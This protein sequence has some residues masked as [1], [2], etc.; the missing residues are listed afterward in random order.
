M[1]KYIKAAFF[2]SPQI[3]GLGAVPVNVLGIIGFVALGFGHPGFWLLGLGLETAYL[4]ATATN[5]RFQHAV[6]ARESTA[7]EEDDELVR[8]RL[9]RKL[10]RHAKRR[11]EI[12]EERCLKVLHAHRMEDGDTDVVDA[13]RYA[14]KKLAWTYLKLLVA[15]HELQNP[16]TSAGEAELVRDIRTLESEIVNERLS[17]AARD[18]KVATLEILKKRLRNIER[19]E[20]YIEEIES[21]LRRIEAEVDLALE[22]ATL[23]ES[24]DVIST[25]LD[26]ASYLLTDVFVD[27]EEEASIARVD[28]SMEEERRTVQQPE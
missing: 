16:H 14:L 17:V 7:M 18:S 4:Y 3:P 23:K 8:S 28:R 27:E 2:F 12:L 10:P 11:L 5:D 19:R 26:V 6:R 9:I 13:N 20:R 22:N 25:D 24:P 21:N 1:W 15:S